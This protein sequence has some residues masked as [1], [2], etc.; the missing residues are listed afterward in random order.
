MLICFQPQFACCRVHYENV[1]IP[2]GCVYVLLMQ[3]ENPYLEIVLNIK[4]IPPNFLENVFC[5]ACQEMYP[6]RAGHGPGWIMTKLVSELQ[7]NLRIMEQVSF[8]RITTV[9]M[10]ARPF[11]QIAAL[12]EAF[13]NVTLVYILLNVVHSHFGHTSCLCFYFECSFCQVNI[14][15]LVHVELIKMQG[16]QCAI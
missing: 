15:L 7:V 10:E 3:G 16:F 11:S 12:R 1:Q 4:E 14:F 9:Q 8:C 5:Q 13:R 6:L 2:N